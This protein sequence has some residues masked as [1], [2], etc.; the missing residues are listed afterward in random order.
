ML[1]PKGNNRPISGASENRKGDKRAAG[2]S[3]A[4]D[5]GFGKRAS[6]KLLARCS[7]DPRRSGGTVGVMA[8]RESNVI[9]FP[10]R[11]DP[12]RKEDVRIAEQFLEK[13]DGLNMKG[14]RR[15]LAAAEARVLAGDA[16][17]ARHAELLFLLIRRRLRDRDA[18]RR[19]AI[20]KY[21]LARAALDFFER[22]TARGHGGRRG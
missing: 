7:A 11:I 19:E 16:G 22:M 1:E 12:E 4:A 13:F 15:D 14:L 2:V 18:I 9:M 8:K 21:V 10:W 5:L 17:A 3:A 6:G 20:A